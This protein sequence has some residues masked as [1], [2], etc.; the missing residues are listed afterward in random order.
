MLQV[1][2]TFTF[3]VADWR[4]V[5]DPSDVRMFSITSILQLILRPKYTS[6]MVLFTKKSYSHIFLI[7]LETRRVF[8]RRWC[9]DFFIF[10]NFLKLNL[11]IFFISQPAWS[12]SASWKQLKTFSS[13]IL[14]VS[15]LP[16]LE[17]ERPGSVSFSSRS[18]NDISQSKNLRS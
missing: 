2:Q 5:Q 18:N 12:V 9:H 8:S 1:T 3:L 4:E 6:Y 11:F 7:S 17:A 10:V 15:Q 14:P 16:K 13:G